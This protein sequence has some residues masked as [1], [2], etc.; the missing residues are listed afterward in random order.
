MIATGGEG[1]PRDY[2]NHMCHVVETVECLP[3]ERCTEES[4]GFHKG[5]F[6]IATKQNKSVSS[7][8][9]MSEEDMADYL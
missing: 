9:F 3:L 6:Q 8:L 2:L 4:I 5:Y 7:T 1:I